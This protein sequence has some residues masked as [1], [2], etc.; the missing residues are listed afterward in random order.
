MVAQKKGSY[1]ITLSKGSVKNT[2]GVSS[3]PSN[4]VWVQVKDE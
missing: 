4:T 1:H 3:D 2:E